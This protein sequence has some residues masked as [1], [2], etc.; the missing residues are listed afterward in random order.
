MK[1][2]QE[3]NALPG[4]P[5]EV[6]PHPL[7]WLD[8]T[9]VL[10]NALLGKAYAGTPR[11]IELENIMIGLIEKEKATFRTIMETLCAIELS[12]EEFVTMVYA[13]GHYT[14]RIGL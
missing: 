2:N 13:L 9:G 11:Q 8:G 4:T 12:D 5:T 7:T 3:L 10:G 14:G 1:T 6:R